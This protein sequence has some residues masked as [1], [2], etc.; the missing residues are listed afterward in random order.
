MPNADVE[1]EVQ[2]DG[3]VLVTEHLTYDFD[4]S[5]S[6]AFREIPL[7]AGETMTDIQVLEGGTS[8]E[9]GACTQLGCSDLPG[10]FG[11]VNLG[12]RVRIVWH[13]SAFNEPR[14][15]TVSYR[16]D[17]LAVA[18][19]D[20]VDVNLQVWGDEWAVPL[21]SLSAIMMLPGE[22]IAPE[23]RVWGHPASVDGATNLGA[24]GVSPSLL[25][26][27]IPAGQ[28]VELRVMFPRDLLDSTTGAQ[29]VPG[30]GE[31]LILDDELRNAQAASREATFRRWA[32]VFGVV[33][34]IVP[35]T[36]AVL[37]IYFR[38]GREPKVYYDREYEQEPPSDH[39]PA[40]V[41]GLLTQGHVGVAEFTATMFELIHRGVLAARPV[42]IEKS[43]WLGLRQE[44]IS[45]LELSL[46]ED[47]PPLSG[48]ESTVLT[49]M[50]RILGDGP[51]PLTEFRHLIREDVTA[52]AKS[53]ESFEKQA[54]KELEASELMTRDRRK[55]VWTAALIAAAILVVGGLLGLIGSSDLGSIIAPILVAVVVVNGLILAIFATSSSASTTS[56]SS[57]RFSCIAVSECVRN[58]SFFSASG[59]LP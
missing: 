9:F 44:Q 12:G 59:I 39:T 32:W 58:S 18:Y 53:Y 57:C 19:D 1:V 49:V 2:S 46:V 6:G 14:T 47:A 42:T 55:P 7:G 10:R 29:V 56:L 34:A 20:V 22:A 23:V 36:V 41:G 13:Y 52:N 28:F 17:G 4:G 43:T 27:R 31:E 51:Q 33:M 5:F 16:I 11:V 26:N 24:D 38:Y 45:D 25:A 48:P 15:F 37:W 8:Y 40:V 54:R 50:R 35:A 3:S 30:N 21:D